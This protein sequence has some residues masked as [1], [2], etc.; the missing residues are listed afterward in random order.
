MSGRVKKTGGSIEFKKKY[1]HALLF[2][3]GSANFGLEDFLSGKFE[4][5]K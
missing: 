1:P 2:T 4:L 5:F 3:V